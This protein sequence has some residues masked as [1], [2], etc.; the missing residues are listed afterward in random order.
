S[1]GG[2]GKAKHKVRPKR[3]RVILTYG[4]GQIY[5]PHGKAFLQFRFHVKRGFQVRGYVCSL[6]RAKMHRCRSPQRFHVGAG[7]HVFRVRARPP[8]ARAAPRA[9]SPPRPPRAPP[10]PPRPGAP[11]RACPPPAGAGAP[12]PLGDPP[13][14]PARARPPLPSAPPACPSPRSAASP[15]VR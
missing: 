1:G 6:D 10:P 15:P 4:S 14:L 5:Q 7:H 3:P 13:A 9:R 12:R 2:K 11:P 8:R